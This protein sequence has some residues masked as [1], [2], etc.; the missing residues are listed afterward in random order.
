M[1]D[2]ADAFEG[3]DEPPEEPDEVEAAAG[4]AS[5]L[6]EPFPED[7]PEPEESLPPE[8]PEDEPLDAEEPLPRESVR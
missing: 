8:E 4:F 2:E 3:V 1:D 7:E 5:E 6:E